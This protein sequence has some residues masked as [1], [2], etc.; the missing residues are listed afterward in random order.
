[1]CVLQELVTGP[2]KSPSDYFTSADQALA[3]QLQEVTDIADTD[4]VRKAVRLLADFHPQI[5]HGLG[6][7]SPAVIKRLIGSDLSD[8]CL[9]GEMNPQVIETLAMMEVS[10]VIEMSE[11]NG[12]SFI[13]DTLQNMTQ[14][15]PGVMLAISNMD[16]D[17]VSQFDSPQD[18]INN[19]LQKEGKDDSYTVGRL[20][21]GRGGRFFRG[22]ARGFFRGRGTFDGYR[23]KYRGG[24]RGRFRGNYRGGYRGGYRGDY[25]HGF[26]A[27][28]RGNSEGDYRGGYKGKHWAGFSGEGR[29]RFKRHYDDDLDD[30]EEPPGKRSK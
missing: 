14:A 19:V 7:V 12:M 11:I 15:D 6:F 22:A 21:R 26:R 13:L 1:M 27:G 2:Q 17:S 10:L 4:L 18:L 8:L 24:N 23:G 5:V 29:G 20:F 16:S 30:F 3:D 28:Y 25:R 9:L